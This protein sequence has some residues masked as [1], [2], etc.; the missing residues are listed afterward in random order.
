MSSL[1]KQLNT[2]LLRP[3]QKLMFN[4]KVNLQQKENK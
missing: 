3:N 4:K 1:K 2:L